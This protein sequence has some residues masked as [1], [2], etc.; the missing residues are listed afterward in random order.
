M[1][2]YIHEPK[3]SDQPNSA[4][5]YQSLLCSWGLSVTL[6]TCQHYLQICMIALIGDLVEAQLS[7]AQWSSIMSGLVSLVQARQHGCSRQLILTSSKEGS[8]LAVTLSCQTYPSVEWLGLWT[9][10]PTY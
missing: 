10:I 7:E 2:Y 4:L 8:H 6:H 1:L 5:S 3:S 9:P